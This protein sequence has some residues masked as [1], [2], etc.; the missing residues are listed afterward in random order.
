MPADG[1][2]HVRRYYLKPLLD[3]LQKAGFKIDWLDYVPAYSMR[4]SIWSDI[5][6]KNKPLHR[7]AIQCVN[8]MLSFL[9]FAVRY[10]LAHIWPDRFALMFV[11]KASKK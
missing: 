8:L 6:K 10:R 1:T 3:D 7:R 2:H 11:L 4:D 5:R 9:P